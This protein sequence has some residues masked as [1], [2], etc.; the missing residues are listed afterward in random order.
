MISN[1][2]ASIR[3]LDEGIYN[4]FRKEK[5]NISE[6]TMRLKSDGYV[7]LNHL[8]GSALIDGIS[9]TLQQKLSNFEFRK[10]LLAQSKVDRSVHKELI[11]N[12]FLL[13][14]DALSKF[15]ISATINSDDTLDNFVRR[16]RPTTLEVDMPDD[17]HFYSLWL[18]EVVL[19][20]VSE[21]FGFKPVLCEAFI[22]RNYPSEFHVMNHGWHRDQNHP[23]FLLKA[24]IFLNDCDLSNGP[25][26]FLA[27][28][29]INSELTKRNYYTDEEV[30]EYSRS[31]GFKEVISVVPKGTIILEDTRGL[32]KAGIPTRHFRD[33]GF[34]TFMPD[35]AIMKRKPDYLISKNTRVHLNTRQNQFIL[36]N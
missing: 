4:L 24:F 22:R 15:G 10:P 3:T 13:Q 36:N 35:R 26:H 5:S 27:K 32:H 20:I 2:K 21:Y 17:H 28:S 9:E 33:L 12:N 18:N 1:L 7:I 6:Q 31:S 25:H 8:I 14:R 34:A 23:S 16:E 19:D 11:K 29:H 30:R